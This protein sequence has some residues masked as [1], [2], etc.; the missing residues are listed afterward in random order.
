MDNRSMGIGERIKRK[1]NENQMTQTQL[2]ERLGVAMSTVYKWEAGA[3]VPKYNDLERIANA[4]GCSVGYLVGDVMHDGPDVV[5]L[6]VLGPEAAVCAGD[7]NI[8]EGGVVG[9]SEKALPLPREMIGTQGEK[10]PFCVIVEGNSMEPAGIRDGATVA[11]NPDEEAR[12][13]DLVVACLYGTTLV[14]KWFFPRRDG[15]VELRSA[16][17]G[18]SSQVFSRE[19]VDA[20]DCILLGKVVAVLSRPPR[21]L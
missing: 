11:V 21:G 7:G 20:G 13:G 18:Y 19:D 8:Y 15:S 2:G 17:D 3:S 6:P 1:R 12:A 5:M 10:Q 14:T 4:L 9:T 16:N